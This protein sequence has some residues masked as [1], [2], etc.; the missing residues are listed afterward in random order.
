MEAGLV[1]FDTEVDVVPNK[2]IEPPVPV[3]IDERG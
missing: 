2:Q 3:V 1:P